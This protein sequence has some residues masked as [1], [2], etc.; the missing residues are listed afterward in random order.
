MYVCV[1]KLKKTQGVAV[2]EAQAFHCERKG[3]ADGYH[4]ES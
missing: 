1:K 4:F 3:L 2:N